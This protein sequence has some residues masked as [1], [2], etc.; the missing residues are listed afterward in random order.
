M[1][2]LGD[3]HGGPHEPHQGVLGDIGLTAGHGQHSGA[4]QHQEGAQH[5]E[6]PHELG[7]QPYA[8]KYHPDAHEDGA[9]HAI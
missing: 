9:Q 3:P 4:A 2:V 6:H 1:I 8:G 7:Q 5:I